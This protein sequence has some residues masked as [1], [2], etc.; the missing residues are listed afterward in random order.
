MG[1][2]YLSGVERS[3]RNV[4]IDNTG[5]AEGSGSTHVNGESAASGRVNC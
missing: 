3:E 1:R 2:T 4:S 5:V